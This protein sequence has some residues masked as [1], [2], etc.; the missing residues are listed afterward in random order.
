MSPSPHEPQSRIT[1]QEELGAWPI[2]PI[3]Q[4]GYQNNALRDTFR[5]CVDYCQRLGALKADLPGLGQGWRAL[6]LARPGPIFAPPHLGGPEAKIAPDIRRF[7]L[8]KLNGVKQALE[9]I[10]RH[11]E[12]PE[13]ICAVKR[14]LVRCVFLPVVWHTAARLT[15]LSGLVRLLPIRVTD[16]VCELSPSAA[17]KSQRYFLTRQCP[18]QDVETRDR[19]P[20]GLPL[21]TGVLEL[22]GSS[23]SSADCQRDF[24]SLLDELSACAL[25][26]TNGEPETRELSVML[27]EA[28]QIWHIK[29]R[30][31]FRHLFASNDAGHLH[32]RQL[33]KLLVSQLWHMQE[34]A[35]RPYGSICAKL[36]VLVCASLPMTPN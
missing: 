28:L 35:N 34:T 4:A 20:G 25:S 26:G 14:I 22:P 11:A 15:S 21:Y 31:S 2:Q 8:S 18:L 3:T 29:M 32:A 1:E 5:R 27:L 23:G 13:R 17:F 16:Q 12:L 33:N 10:S 30:Y 19:F 7:V 9:T 6:A 24:M 36:F